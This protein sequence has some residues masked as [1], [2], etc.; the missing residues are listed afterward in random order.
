MGKKKRKIASTSTS[1]NNN[2]KNNRNLSPSVRWYWTEVHEAW[3]SSASPR[4]RGAWGKEASFHG[5][6][7]AES[8]L[9]LRGQPLHP[10]RPAPPRSK[11]TRAAARYAATW[12]AGARRGDTRQLLG[13]SLCGSR[14]G[15]AEQRSGAAEQGLNHGMPLLAVEA[16]LDAVQGRGGR[17]LAMHRG[18][19]FW[20]GTLPI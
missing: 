13:Q 11:P 8:T 17:C 1:I 3:R 18:M 12:T 14:R 19:L 20:D 15:A 7:S 10:L 4:A 2:D 6:L 9:A 16:K 5:R